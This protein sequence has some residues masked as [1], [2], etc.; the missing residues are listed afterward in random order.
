MSLMVQRLFDAF[1]MAS[2]PSNTWCFVE[3]FQGLIN[4]FKPELL[5]DTD[6][7]FVGGT[8]I[9]V[10]LMG[11]LGYYVTWEKQRDEKVL[12]NYQGII[13]ALADKNDP[14]ILMNPGSD[15]AIP[16]QITQAGSDEQKAVAGIPLHDQ[17]FKSAKAI[18]LTNEKL[19][20]RDSSR[21]ALRTA[22]SVFITALA[23]LQFTLEQ[24][25]NDGTPNT[26]YITFD[27][28]NLPNEIQQKFLE[29]LMPKLTALQKSIQRIT[30]QH[31]KKSGIGIK[32]PCCFFTKR[33]LSSLCQRQQSTNAAP[34][35]GYGAI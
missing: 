26:Q 4:L 16:L 31:N 11:A 27:Q 5:D 22:A 24:Q 28:G 20:V 1:V 35:T 32:R 9:A 30:K 8:L 25:M 29:G 17:I 14:M 34:P 15:A 18:Q 23:M 3:V 19:M 10:V 2:A 13:N 33:R 21:F 6:N 7:R 12:Q